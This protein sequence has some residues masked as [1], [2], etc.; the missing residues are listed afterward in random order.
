MLKVD[1]EGG[2]ASA[3]DSSSVV[4]RARELVLEMHEP[5]LRAQGVDPAAF[6]ERLGPHTMLESP[7]EGN[8][9]VLVTPHA[10]A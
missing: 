1:I 4:H 10:A 9:A 3:L 8:Y 7:D 5:P 2:E 6:L